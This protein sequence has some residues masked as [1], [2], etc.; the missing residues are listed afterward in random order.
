MADAPTSRRRAGIV[1][2]VLAL[3]GPAEGIRHY[4]YYDPPG[5]M[6]VC[7]GHTGRDVVAHQY[8]S[9]GECYAL[10]QGDAGKAVDQ[11]LACAA[12]APE[13]VAVAFGDAVF[14]LGGTI[15]CDRKT[16]TAA[17]L[18]AAGQWRAAC[19]QLPRWDKARVAGAM[20]ALPG[21]TRRR[22]LERNVCLQGVQ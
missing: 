2:G 8:Y 4:A 5:I 7:E 18:L 15:A 6:T 13:S 16:S 1:A 19:E 22:A 10:A 9:D 17:R 12:Q 11:V 21:L 14:N 20:V 3:A